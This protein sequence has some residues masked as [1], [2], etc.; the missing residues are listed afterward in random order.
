LANL[1][2]VVH[3][4]NI[5]YFARDG[6]LLSGHFFRSGS[7]EDLQEV[8]SLGSHSG[9]DVSL[10]AFDVIMKIITK[11]VDQIDGIIP[12]VLVGMSGKQDESDVT[13]VIANPG[14]GVLQLHGWFPVREEDLRR[15]MARFAA[16]FELLHKH[17]ADDD[18]VL[19]FENGGED[20]SDPIGSRLHIHG[21]LIPVVDDS[22]LLS[23]QSF[24]LE[25]E[26]LLENGRKTVS[27]QK[28]RFLY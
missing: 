26:V 10:G 27:L 4:A 13:D 7:V 16:L 22:P 1:E 21:L 19:V 2:F 6:P 17:F 28:T 9:V 15:G 12:R 8:G 3:L 24:L 20:N 5:H 11:S 18:V 25:F 23:L 14:V